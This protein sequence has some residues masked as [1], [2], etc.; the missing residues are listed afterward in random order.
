[1]P[2]NAIPNEATLQLSSLQ[3]SIPPLGSRGAKKMIGNP[4]LPIILLY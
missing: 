4:S 1:L 3:E 2:D